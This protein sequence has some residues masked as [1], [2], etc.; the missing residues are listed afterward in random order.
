MELLLGVSEEFTFDEARLQ[1][2]LVSFP[3]EGNE[4]RLTYALQDFV[5]KRVS[6]R[7]T[8]YQAFKHARNMFFQALLAEDVE[9][10]LSGQPLERAYLWSLTSLSSHLEAIA[11]ERNTRLLSLN[12]QCRDVAS[13]RIF[14]GSSIFM[15]DSETDLNMDVGWMKPQTIYYAREGEDGLSSHPLGDIFFLTAENELVVFDIT[16]SGGTSTAM[17]QKKQHS[18]RFIDA[19]NRGS[20][21]QGLVVALVSPLEEGT[22]KVS[23]DHPQLRYIFGRHARE[24]LG[25]L[26]QFLNWY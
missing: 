23:S 25:G 16:A 5:D 22:S 21:G 3:F 18:K 17:T 13:G 12:F 7:V 6:S 24:L 11:L 8:G 14:P 26:A 1:S 4:A 20:S 15:D 19:W 10:L 9:V 2:R